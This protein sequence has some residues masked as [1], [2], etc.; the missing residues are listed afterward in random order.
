MC[1]FFRQMIYDS[2]FMDSI[3]QWRYLYAHNENN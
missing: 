3:Q 2:Y 1:G